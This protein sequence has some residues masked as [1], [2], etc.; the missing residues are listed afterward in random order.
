MPQITLLGSILP[1]VARITTK[2][3]P[4]ITWT[5]ADLDLSMT[6]TTFIENG[7]VRIVCELSDWRRDDHL[8]PVYM[9]ALDL[10]RAAVDLVAF[11][12]GIGLTVVLDGLVDSDGTPSAFLATQPNL[13]ALSPSVKNASP[14]A[15]TADNNFDR[16][17]RVIATEPVMFRALHDLVVAIT[18]TH[19]SP[20]AC[21]RAVE[22][23]RHSIAPQLEPKQGWPVLRSALNI[24]KDYL[25]YI[26]DTSTGPRHGDPEHIPGYVCLEITRR[27]WIIMDRFFEYLKAGRQ[28][29]S[30]AAFPVLNDP[31]PSAP[32]K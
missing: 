6:F 14:P 3:L 16:V 32:L 8:M 13:A 30:Q 5:S 29:L 1:A 18:E 11:S 26:T 4:V 7:K 2:D 9:R 23:I 10:V 21:A 25:G 31:P 19:A 27:C 24:D 17:L 15:S 20:I 22:G 28:P 12:Y